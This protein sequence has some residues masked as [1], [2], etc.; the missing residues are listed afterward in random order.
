MKELNEKYE[1]LEN[2]VINLNEALNGAKKEITRLQNEN[3]IEIEKSSNYY[4]MYQNLMLE[5]ERRESQMSSELH[6]IRNQINHSALEKEQLS[7]M[8]KIQNKNN[9]EMLSKIIIKPFRY[10]QNF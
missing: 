8:L 6:Q 3:T 9:D 7:K 2:T 4:E 10:P 1:N 5:K